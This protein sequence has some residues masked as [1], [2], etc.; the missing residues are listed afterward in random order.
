MKP[1][2]CWVSRDE[3]RFALVKENMEYFSREDEVFQMFIQRIND[4]LTVGDVETIYVDAT[5]LN[6]KS[7]SKTVNRINRDNVE[8]MNCIYFTTPFEVCLDRNSFRQGRQCV[9]ETAMYNMARSYSKPEFS[10]GFDRIFA[11]D[12]NGDVIEVYE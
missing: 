12:E 2:M 10:E 6:P 11:A 1:G 7:R 5:H 4:L 8:E 9:P 3:F